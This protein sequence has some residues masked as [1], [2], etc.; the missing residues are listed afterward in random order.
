PV[1]ADRDGEVIGGLYGG[2]G[3]RLDVHVETGYTVKVLVYHT[4][5][6]SSGKVPA[7]QYVESWPGENDGIYTFIMPEDNVTVEVIFELDDA[8][9]F[10]LYLSETEQDAAGNTVDNA[11][12][13]I[14]GNST[15]LTTVYTETD[16][17]T[18]PPTSTDT[19]IIVDKDSPKITTS[20]F[21]TLPGE[22]IHSGAVVRADVAL[23]HD[24][25][26]VL[27]F[28]SVAENGNIAPETPIP[29]DGT[30][31]PNYVMVLP[32]GG[33]VYI[34]KGM[35]SSDVVVYVTYRPAQRR[36]AILEV[37]HKDIPPS[38]NNVAQLVTTVYTR[39]DEPRSAYSGV[40]YEDDN[41]PTEPDRYR[42]VESDF[43]VL[44]RVDASSATGSGS[45]GGDGRAPMDWDG[46][47]N[48]LMALLYKATTAADLNTIKPL[49]LRWETT[50]GSS[51]NR[52]PIEG[53]RK[54]AI[55]ERYTDGDMTDFYARLMEIK[56]LADAAIA[57][58]N[59]VV[60]LVTVTP[61]GGTGTPYSYYDLTKEQIQAYLLDYEARQTYLAEQAQYDLD[62][63]QYDLDK[64]A[65]DQY[66]KDKA[67]AEAIG[68]K[69]EGRPVREPKIPMAPIAISA[70]VL[71]SDGEAKSRIKAWYDPATETV[72]P[73][74]QPTVVND[75]KLEIRPGR[76]VAVVL[77]AESSYTVA[78]SIIIRPAIVDNATGKLVSD[79]DR[80]RDIVLDDA[81]GKLVR[82]P[83]YQN[84]FLFDMPDYDCIVEVTYTERKVQ[85][86]DLVVVGPYEHS[87][88]SISEN[89]VKVTG[90][91]PNT[92]PGS[93]T[94]ASITPLV[95]D[96]DKA[97]DVLVDSWVT[98]EVHRGEGY[99]A[100]AQVTYINASGGVS[101]LTTNPADTTDLRES[102]VFTFRMPDNVTT[103][104]VTFI[105]KREQLNA[106]LRF[107]GDTAGGSG[108]WSGTSVIDT[109]A[110]EGD[111]LVADITVEP[112]YY[113]Y[114]I[115]TYTTSGEM[116]ATNPVVLSGNGWNNGN[117][118]KNDQKVTATTTMPGAEYW[119][120][121]YIRKGE[122]EP[123]PDPGEILRLQ[124]ED[125][126]NTGDTIADNW[127]RVNTPTTI[128]PLGLGTTGGN[129]L[130]DWKYAK[131]GDK[132]QLEFHP[133]T[134]YFVESVEVKPAGLGASVTWTSATTAEF[135]MP[136]ASATVVVT[137]RKLTD[138]VQPKG[139]YL[140][141][142]K[143]ER[144]GT[145]ASNT[146]PNF[147]SPT[148]QAL[149]GT[150]VYTVPGLPSTVPPPGG[151]NTGAAK[152]GEWVEIN[153]NIAPGWYIESITASEDGGRIPY[154]LYHTYNRTSGVGVDY[155]STDSTHYSATS[156][157]NAVVRFVMPASDAHITVNY[158][159]GPEDGSTP[160]P[161]PHEH[162]VELLVVDPENVGPTFA[163]NW[164]SSEVSGVDPDR[165]I[166]AV[167]KAKDAMRRATSA[168]AGE[169]VT[170]EYAAD[171]AYALEIILVTPSGLLVPVNYLDG[172]HAR[173]TMPDSSVTAIVRFKRQPAIQYTANLVLHFP[174]GTTY[175]QYD[176]IGE[177][178]FLVD[179]DNGLN[180]PN[181]G[182]KTKLYSRV[183][184]PGTTLPFEMLAH[185]GYYI[186]DVTVGPPTLGVSADYTG[187]FG[188]QTG[189]VIMP[190]A[191]IQINVYFQKG[192][193]DD[194]IPESVPYDLT[195]KVYDATGLGSTAN[196]VSIAG[197][198]LTAPITNVV[199]NGQSLTVTPKQ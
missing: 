71:L 58:S 100:V 70:P 133:D 89:T 63:A 29:T 122:P 5:A 34:D 192:W 15:V 51:V 17:T 159:K 195:L 113:I 178:S 68:Q 146:I 194:I 11:V 160:T 152:A 130:T 73:P 182:A 118:A 48:S 22:K 155:D 69:Y 131:A 66:V 33:T 179:P 41:N 164:A 147:T 13:G 30:I 77:E 193:P 86:L 139:L 170:I 43:R 127:A 132:V 96:G 191:N 59:P 173:F 98:V 109:T 49:D 143:T 94:A 2:T 10:W 120:Y 107:A 26:A 169:V 128:G 47:E 166:A 106:H 37:H 74:E 108:V 171:A 23:H 165:T 136:A 186:S 14:Q 25:E 62:K 88:P 174:D 154:Q 176:S 101:T 190:A 57:V 129:V 39:E 42:T 167:G 16:T 90:Y 157:M 199:G 84:E 150:G 19:V 32:T 55:G 177:G 185:D 184:T 91:K 124:V 45:L 92:N 162:E 145:S 76:Q 102:D 60:N 54:N 28:Y 36:T 8:E 123:E 6:K 175:A 79:P 112:G 181:P 75:Y 85:K 187:A 158:R 103:I 134:G 61:T 141:L 144:G 20:T 189:S 72:T 149:G 142:A 52:Q 188:Y 56:A 35:P 125:P 196:F 183:V 53:L 3:M 105:D 140:H 117:G 4:S 31:I 67:D 115:E 82:N 24:Y 114:A 87:T 156:V 111:T 135:T 93:I 81:S 151:S 172:S 198:A 138:E 116:A 18:T 65:Y 119:V 64:A 99:T 153:V 38:E 1:Y 197:A 9:E 95:Q 104:T 110:L 121:V 44:D 50:A 161:D 168:R 40:V 83:D 12:T 7:I 78:S 27:S 126:D 80:S 180:Y 148:I 46:T 21:G 163:D 97:D 137:F